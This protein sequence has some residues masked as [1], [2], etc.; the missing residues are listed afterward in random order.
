MTSTINIIQI[1]VRTPYALPITVDNSQIMLNSS[2]NSQTGTKDRPRSPRP[3]EEDKKLE[4]VG[5]EK[6]KKPKTAT[7]VRRL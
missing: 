6:E 4:E 7:V 2:N 5:G 3:I 1:K